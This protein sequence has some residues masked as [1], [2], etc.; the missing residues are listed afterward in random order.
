[1]TV[2]KVKSDQRLVKSG[3]KDILSRV[4][5]VYRWLNKK[6]VTKSDE[7]LFEIGKKDNISNL[8]CVC[9]LNTNKTCD[10]KENN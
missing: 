5:C 3:V 7:K 1:M 8:F 4:L 6:K 2:R 10:Q 9:A